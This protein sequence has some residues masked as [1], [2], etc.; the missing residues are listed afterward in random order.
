MDIYSIDRDLNAEY[1]RINKIPEKE[2]KTIISFVKEIKIT[3]ITQHREYFYLTRLRVIYNNLQDK[4]LNPGKEDIIDMIL[5]FK[6]IYTDKT[7]MDYENVMKRFY[8]WYY[9][10]L[11]DFMDIK[12]NHKSSHDK[13]MDL[14]TRYDIERLIGACNNTRDKALVS[15]LYDS[16]C[17][18]GE[19][20]TLRMRDVIFD[21][22]G[23]I[24]NVHGKTGNRNVRIIGDSIAYLK[25]Y[26]KSK[27]D[28]D[29][30]LFTGLQKQN[31]HKQ[32][33]Y[34]DARKLLLNLKARTG[35]DKRIY[36]HLFRHTRASILASKVPE[37]PLESQ[38]GWIHGS[39]MTSIYVHLSM[40]DQD[41]AILKAYGINI[42]EK[43]EIEEKPKKC[44]RCDYLNPLNAKYCHNCWL[45]FD[46]KLALEYE[47]REREI[48]DK[49]E[50]SNIIPGIAKKM[51]ENAP[52]SFKYKL[53]ENVL[54][55]ILKDPEMLNR[56]RNE[57]K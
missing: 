27:D 7:I 33:K 49:I 18:I 26:L 41:N 21:E 36:P 25:D 12:F 57:L 3:G 40:R 14:I 31:M 38:M 47:N 17:R 28:N 54:E 4:F 53:I 48:E 15:L 24:L 9:K 56:F 1:K 37:S 8:K 29:E 34:Y 32:M 39:K 51:I 46:E 50:K 16:G 22:Y 5:R 13:K 42:N 19:I 10:S 2:R 11:P 30:Y 23:L 44:P 52:E 45:P 43:N 20:L 55:E 6:E 35:I